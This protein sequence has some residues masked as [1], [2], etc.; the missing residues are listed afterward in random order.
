MSTDLIQRRR[1]LALVPYD[2]ASWLAIGHELPTSG[3]HSRAKNCWFRAVHLAP[4]DPAILSDAGEA[5]RRDGAAGTSAPWLRRAAAL[6]P[7]AAGV[8]INL[9]AALREVAPAALAVAAF[10]RA[11]ALDA[12]SAAAPYNLAVALH[13]G[14]PAAARRYLDAALLRQPDLAAAHHLAAHLE[15]APDRRAA[16]ARRALTP[17]PDNGDAWALLG[18]AQLILGDAEAARRSYARCA[19]IVPGDL[20]IAS[21]YLL[22]LNYA[23]TG[24]AGEIAARHRAYG[25]RF[26]PR[27]R[28]TR[29]PAGPKDRLRVGL[30]SGDFRWHSTAFFLPPLLRHRR[31]DEFEYRLY[32]NVKSPDAM[33]ERFKAWSDA[34]VDIA[35]LD[36]DAVARRLVDDRVDV[37]V[38]LNGHTQGNRLGVLARRAVATQATW[39]DYVGSTG[40]SQVDYAVTDWHHSPAGTEGDYVESLIRLPDNRFCYE[41]PADSPPVVASPAI[42]AGHA[43]FGY[44]GAIYKL[45]PRL[46]SAWSRILS[47]APASRLRLIA[48]DSAKPR[49]HGIFEGLGV[50]PGRV[51]IMAS[52][53][54]GELLARYGTVDI[55]LDSFPYSG[56]LTTCEALWMGV[57][58]V[59]FPGDRVAGRHATAHL[60]TAGLAELIADDVEGYVA[61]AVSLAEEPERI[62]T[63]RADLRRRL[64]ASPL[65]DGPRF[66]RSF[67]DA[68]RRMH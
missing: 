46:F 65:T 41:P 14:D 63:L 7:A 1:H 48:P 47:R 55:A 36:D 52:V 13:R 39:L 53:P 40:L 16:A 17:T 25:R 61:R 8:Q 5:M 20:G 42:R 9:G 34:W 6:D 32:S 27:P 31:R 30:I 57:P 66:A 26:P 10:L 21:T 64:G 35:N 11:L 45:G 2:A 12:A 19:A 38:D 54:H 37:L 18:S 58:V 56:G 43:T 50:D 23:E 22:V 49:L 62:A 3:R 29:R 4:G 67:E 59:T 60:R 15:P 68:L 24:T 51:D 44:F 33:T 28:P